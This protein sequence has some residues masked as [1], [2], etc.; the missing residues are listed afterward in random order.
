MRKVSYLYAL[1][2]LIFLYFPI[3][4]VI[5]YSFNSNGDMLYFSQFSLDAYYQLLSDTNLLVVI[6]NTIIIGLSSSF[7][8]VI[9]GFCG[10]FLLYEIKNKRFKNIISV[11]NSIFLV[12]PDVIIGTS[13]LSLFTL[14]EIKLGF[15]SV[16]LAHIAFSVPVAV[17]I[18]YTKLSTIN[19]RV[20]DA[21]SDLGASNYEI[22]KLVIL[23]LIL[24]ALIAAFLTTLSYSIDDFAVTFFVTGNGF[25]T[26]AINIYTQARQGINLTINAL[27]SIIFFLTM[28]GALIY[29]L[30]IKRKEQHEKIN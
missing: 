13:L 10:A 1:M 9:I 17:I 3:L 15:I 14:L 16:F 21:A 5:F 28:L 18:I 4:Y 24:P 7:I 30:I 23:P 22:T 29:F 26:L 11:F 27:S 8:S 20:I 6:L 25:Q 2:M 12:S 19:K